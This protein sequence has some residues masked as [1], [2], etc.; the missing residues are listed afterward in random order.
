[1]K[2]QTNKGAIYG[3]FDKIEALI[4]FNSISKFLINSGLKYEEECLKL[5]ENFQ[6]SISNVYAFGSIMTSWNKDLGKPE[7]TFIHN[8]NKEKSKVIL[9]DIVKKLLIE[10]K[11]PFNSRFFISSPKKKI[12]LKGK[13][14]ILLKK[15]C[16]IQLN[17]I[18]KFICGIH[19]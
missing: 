15:F 12:T 11:I 2:I 13:L 7:Q 10:K 16:S 19:F 6:T 1:M 14:K 17:F 3:P 18:N 9:N 4:G 5:N 8:G